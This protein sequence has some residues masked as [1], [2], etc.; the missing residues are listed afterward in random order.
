M[1]TT[2][3]ALLAEVLRS[4]DDDEWR[5]LYADALV[6]LGDVRGELIH[7]QL[8][9]STLPVSPERARLEARAT[10]LLREHEASWAPPLGPMGESQT[11]TRGF[12]ETLRVGERAELPPGHAPLFPDHPVR[13]L[14]AFTNDAFEAGIPDVVARLPPLS[15]LEFIGLPPEELLSLEGLGGA[16]EL[17]TLALSADRLFIP[18]PRLRLKGLRS[19]SLRSTAGDREVEVLCRQAWAPQLRA[20]SLSGELSASGART[21]AR[22]H[23]LDGLTSLELAG[24]FR[25]GGAG[26]RALGEFA[27]PG[28][29][30]LD[31]SHC[32]MGG[33]GLRALL[34]MPLSG[35]THFSAHHDRLVAADVAPLTAALPEGLTHLK[36]ASNALGNAGV[37]QL[38]ETLRAPRLEVLELGVNGLDARAVPP[39]LAHLPPSV[40]ALSLTWNPLGSD[41]LDAL[42]GN[43]ALAQLH[44]LDLGGT[45]A[46]ER[47]LLTLAK[48]PFLAGLRT[49]NLHALVLSPEVTR[50]L[51]ENP[52]LEA[53]GEL[54]VDLRP[55]FVRDAAARLLR[56][57]FGPVLHQRW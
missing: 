55:E 27:A 25:L 42:A 15:R 5:R 31:V 11:F 34:R 41:G 48:S 12:V 29:R 23:A 14:T 18:I 47:G 1:A 35:L 22:S 45:K 6:E 3:Q 2:A 33:E 56:A 50:A 54:S 10:E 39:L 7:V 13:A 52:A 9:S 26:F 53:L 51:C 36:L 37:Q 20:L 8:R 24:N 49:L 44:T 28:L 4:P 32:D 38:L 16:P 57:R 30:V 43:P 17:H 21:L 19:L 46:G 40:R